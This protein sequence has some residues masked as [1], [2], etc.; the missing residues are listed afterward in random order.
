MRALKLYC[1]TR[2]EWVKEVSLFFFF[3]FLQLRLSSVSQRR[4][5]GVPCVLRGVGAHMKVGGGRTSGN[6]DIDVTHEGICP[7]IGM[8]G[9]IQA[10]SLIKNMKRTKRRQTCED[11]GRYKPR[12]AKDC[13]EPPEARTWHG[14]NSPSQTLKRT[15]S[16]KTLILIF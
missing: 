2:V 6:K 11:R 9:W 13:Q 5:L 3:F 14:T 7:S 1:G 15:N 8:G 16:A 12:N 4:R 10:E